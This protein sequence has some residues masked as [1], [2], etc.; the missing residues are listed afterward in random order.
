M[1]AIKYYQKNLICKAIHE[2]KDFIKIIASEYL[3][4]ILHKRLIIE[5]IYSKKK[6]IERMN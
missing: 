3:F 6:V 2:L 4:T 1:W 5:R